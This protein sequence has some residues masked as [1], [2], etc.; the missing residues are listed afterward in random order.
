MKSTIAI[1]MQGQLIRFLAVFLAALTLAACGGGDGFPGYLNDAGVT[2]E[3]AALRIAAPSAVTV[4][5]GSAQSY[6][7]SGGMAPYLV[8]SSNSTVVPA[9]LIGDASLSVPGNAAGSAT[10]S[11]F[12]S[13]NLSVTLDVTVPSA[14][15]AAA[16]FVMAP[17]AGV[18]LATAGTATYTLG[19]GSAGY[20]VVS[21]NPAVVTASIV[22]SSL[23]LS[24]VS[25]GTA[26]LSIFDAAHTRLSLAVTV[27]PANATAFYIMAPESGVTLLAPG[28]ASYTLGGGSAGYQVVSS[29]SA[30]VTASVV[31][32]NLVLSGVS[33]GA[34]TLS[35]FDAAHARL[36]LAVNVQPAIATP[37]ITPVPL[38]TTAPAAITIAIGAKPTYAIAGGNPHYHAF[39][40]NEIIAF[41]RE[42]SGTLYI[43]GKSS[44]S[45][46]VVI[47][48]DMGATR[49]ISVTVSSTTSTPLVV[50]PSAATAN[51]GDV[52]TFRVSGGSPDY[53][54]V[55]NNPAIAS[56]TPSSVGSGQSFSA[57]LLH[58]GITTVAVVD[59][60]GQSSL[61]T[62]TATTNLPA[63][64]VLTLSPAALTVGEDYVEPIVLK[65]QN[66]TAPY[67]AFTS[68]LKLSGVPKAPFNEKT[69]S[70]DPSPVGANRCITPG[71]VTDY[72]P[73]GTYPIT[74]TV[75]DALGAATTTVLT[76]Q[77]NGQGVAGCP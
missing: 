58:G 40:S 77:D 71:G 50:T 29:N 69:F 45:A 55:V 70:V 41:A 22:G 15:A 72:V 48:D 24:G 38:F 37:V 12:D 9:T 65:I 47:T 6:R 49:T 11:V 68:D 44:G 54:F 20:Q 43:E 73:W 4:S 35:I 39:S 51:V 57:T 7:I 3:V 26:T 53:G 14:G 16:F 1:R 59:A 75:L 31:G 5:L 10:V 23:N 25:T 13:S 21:S 32:S 62:L 42:D 74:I 2:T 18:T 56:L 52:L 66:G 28:T 33:T 60:M 61:L 17:E 36:S 76:I 8:V 63:P 27:Q 67:R 34:A 19:G 30:V 46:S 64:A